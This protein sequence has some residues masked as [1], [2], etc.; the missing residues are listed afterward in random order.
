MSDLR[1]CRRQVLVTQ[2]I[3]T[4]LLLAI[5]LLATDWRAPGPWGNLYAV[6]LGCVLGIVNTLLTGRSVLRASQT[7]QHGKGLGMLPLYTGLV[8]KFLLVA[9][10]IAV[11]GL[12]LQW[13]LPFIILGFVVMQVGF[14]FCS[15]TINELKDS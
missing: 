8:N 4:V 13:S 9:G 10:G 12:V 15:T 7:L 1:R 5:V 14:L 3:M 2:M 6:A 11:G